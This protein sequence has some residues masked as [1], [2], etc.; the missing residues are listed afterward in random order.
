MHLSSLEEICAFNKIVKRMVRFFVQDLQSASLLLR[1]VS[2]L[3]T[4]NGAVCIILF[5]IIIIF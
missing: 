2:C 5:I 1:P 3:A 4:C